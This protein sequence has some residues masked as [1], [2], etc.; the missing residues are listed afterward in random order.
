MPQV[1]HGTDFENQMK[2]ELAEKWHRDM[3]SGSKFKT[4][5]VSGGGAVLPCDTTPPNTFRFI[6][7]KSFS[8]KHI[9]WKPWF[10]YIVSQNLLFSGTPCGWC[11]G[12]EMSRPSPF[13]REDNFL[14]GDG[15]TH[16]ESY[17]HEDSFCGL[18]TMRIMSSLLISIGGIFLAHNVWFWG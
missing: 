8:Q 14:D 13:T 7:C 12:L 4:T 1:R 3:L 2:I 9:R 10:C 15:L 5:A 17:D 16:D 18:P 6:F 11:S